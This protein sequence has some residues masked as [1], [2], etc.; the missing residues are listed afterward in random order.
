MDRTVRMWHISVDGE[1]LRV[2]RHTEFVTVV[3]FHPL[4]EMLFISGSIDGKVRLWDIPNVRVTDFADCSEMVTAAA[5]SPGGDKV[6]VGTLEGKCRFYNFSSRFSY[7]AQIDVGNRKTRSRK[8]TGFQFVPGEPEKVLISSNDS[9]LRLYDL[10]EYQQRCKYK[11]HTN[12]SSQIR[13]SFS[14][15][16]RYII[17]GSDHGYVY[18]WP[19]ANPV[20]PAVNPSYTGFRKDKNQSY[21]CFQLQED[22]VTVALFGPESLRRH[23]SPSL[24]VASPPTRAASALLPSAWQWSPERGVLRVGNHSDSKQNEAR[25]QDSAAAVPALREVL[26]AAGNEGSIKIFEN[27]APARWL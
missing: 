1:C 11:G 6:V 13:A 23:L 24:S 25:E 9:R 3:E 27:T 21:E 4:N 19:T 7:E 5:F 2:F 8:I 12:R 18:L 17:C 15:D 16:G 26:V 22:I 14:K 20:I 10:N